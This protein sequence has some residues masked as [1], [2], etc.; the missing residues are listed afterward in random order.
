MKGKAR[1]IASA[2]TAL[3]LAVMMTVNAAAAQFND[4]AGHWAS[5]VI[6]KWSDAGIISGDGTGNFRPDA[7]IT[8]AEFASMLVQIMGYTDVA[9]RSEV[10]DL[11]DWYDQIIL[12]AVAAGVISPDVNGNVNPRSP[13]SRHAMAVMMALA[14]KL[15]PLSGATA[16]VDDA[17]I[18]AYAKGYIKALQQAGHLSGFA[19]DGGY[20][21]RPVNNLSKAESAAIVDMLA[22]N[23]INAAGASS[24]SVEGNLIVNASGVNLRNMTINGDLYLAPGIG[25]GD[26]NLNGVKVTGD[27]ILMGNGQI[28][29]NNSS[30]DDAKV[31]SGG[32]AYL[33]LNGSS[34]LDMI[35]VN[36]GAV[37]DA[38]GLTGGSV[39][40]VM[41]LGLPKDEN[42]YL[43]GNF[44]MVT[45]TVD[46]AHIGIDGTVG[47]INQSAAATITGDVTV[48]GTALPASAASASADTSA[49]TAPP[50]P[51]NPPSQ[52]YPTYTAT[53]LPVY[54][55]PPTYY[56]PVITGLALSEEGS[57]ACG[58][59]SRF[60]VTAYYTPFGQTAYD[61]TFVSSNPAAV[62][63]T[64]S[65][66]QAIINVLSPGTAVIT[67]YSGGLRASFTII[68]FIPPEQ[69][70]TEEYKAIVAEI[71]A[72]D[73]EDYTP[74]SW[75]AFLEAIDGLLDLT[76]TAQSQVTAAVE[77]LEEALELLEE[78]T[79]TDP[80]TVTSVS[81][82]TQPTDRTYV[83]GEKL[84]LA[85]LTV[86]LTYSDETTKI[87]A[88]ADFNTNG[89]TASP[90]NETVMDVAAHN[91]KPV[92]IT[93]TASG[94]TASTNNLTVT[95][96]AVTPTP[97]VTVT[98]VS[99]SNTAG[100][101]VVTV[102]ATAS[103]YVTGTTATVELFT[104]TGTT[105]AYSQTGVA[106]GSNGTISHTFNTVAN[107]TYTAKV[108]VGTASATSSSSITV[109]VNPLDSAKAS[110]KAALAALV[111]GEVTD[112]D[113]TQS[114]YTTE[115]WA[116][117]QNAIVAIK[118]AI[119]AEIDAL[120]TVAEVQDYD[121]LDDYT[122]WATD[123]S[124]A[125]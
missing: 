76:F 17:E 36:G 69:P 41:V 118:T 104:A 59:G 115:S 30:A 98:G 124:A 79:P 106:I 23:I 66:G 14:F 51:T 61:A 50:A 120:T 15:E 93:H 12:K 8:L 112:L 60:T 113:L 78:V 70:D 114:E 64:Y 10:A 99:V 25:L 46:G 91:G 6:D 121:A 63:V 103:N 40:Q 24:N 37:I 48:D 123:F 100:T 35:L 86:T 117:F 33:E 13:L 20:E 89:L 110:A 108:T 16:F 77:A 65:N 90:A 73:E 53:P 88:L 83:T 84:S 4:T 101:S 58:I 119:N 87:V 116:A 38:S 7:P 47:K 56:P 68:A 26:V 82:T 96:A 43:T 74:E 32:R 102:T 125:Q 107:E 111:D 2:L 94:K 1:R 29:I 18:P 122:D 22:P 19:V 44:G 92:V 52:T 85:G 71:E 3:A 34:S 57:M 27:I 21:F 9:D 75:E 97:A 54:T 80:A 72:L 31:Y 67:A 81:V 28:T 39:Q 62:S 42:V 5:E 55:N 105:A 11:G 45:N 109:A 49:A 95:E